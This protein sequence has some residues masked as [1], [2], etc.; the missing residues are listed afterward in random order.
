MYG[1]LLTHLSIC[2]FIF[3]LLWKSLAVNDVTVASHFLPQ[4]YMV[5]YHA[6]V[7]SA[8]S[9]GLDIL[10]DNTMHMLLVIVFSYSV[11]HLHCISHFIWIGYF[12]GFVG[13]KI[14]IWQLLCIP[15]H[16]HRETSSR[17]FPFILVL[18]LSKLTLLSHPTISGYADS[19]VIHILTSY[20]RTSRKFYFLTSDQYQ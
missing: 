8:I 9:S 17:C 20:S 5:F 18:Y 10:V 11:V 19:K 15:L 14:A 12:S 1:W 7:S 13:Y 16:I 6:T 2:R 4:W 3:S